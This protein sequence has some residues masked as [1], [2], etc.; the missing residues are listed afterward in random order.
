MIAGCSE[1]QSRT[2][3]IIRI[4]ALYITNEQ[5]VLL[6]SHQALQDVIDTL[7]SSQSMSNNIGTRHL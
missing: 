3:P 4:V 5:S 1:S 6:P 7:F 2:G